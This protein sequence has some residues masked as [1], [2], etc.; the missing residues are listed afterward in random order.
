MQ[1]LSRMLVNVLDEVKSYVD[2]LAGK[3]QTVYD[4]LYDFR[5]A[6]GNPSCIEQVLAKYSKVKAATCQQAAL[7]FSK[8]GG[9]LEQSSD[10]TYHYVIIDEAARSNPLDLLIPMARGQRVILVGDQNQL[11]HMLEPDVTTRVLD[12]YGPEERRNKEALLR[13]SLFQRLYRQLQAQD[14]VRRVTMLEDQYRMHPVIGDF[15]SSCFYNGK[16]RSK[17]T[18]EAK[19][20]NLGL[21][22][23]KPVVWINVPVRA[24]EERKVGTSRE[25]PAEIDRI[26]ETVQRIYGQNPKFSIGIITFYLAQASK[27][28]ARLKSF[29]IEFQQH[30]ECGTVDAFQGKEFDAVI[31]STVRSNAYLNHRRRVGFLDN[32]NRL[33]VAFSRAKRLLIVIGDLETVAGSA[34]HP[35]IPAFESFCEL[36]QKEGYYE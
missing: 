4:V 9:F 11:P 5:D 23:D 16:L 20:H 19:V 6:I 34:T 24:G 7:H 12:Q 30:V 3:Q 17:A 36:C 26:I 1:K 31:L 28:G 18:A 15:V 14:G 29:P 21:F 22:D 35:V 2:S 8:R 13:E 33:C 27:I 32:T 10:V 25:R